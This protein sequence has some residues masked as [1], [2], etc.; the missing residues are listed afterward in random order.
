MMP[1]SRTGR[2]ADHGYMGT[3]PS[4]SR[5]RRTRTLRVWHRALARFLGPF[6][7]EGLA[8]GRSPDGGRLRAARARALVAPACRDRLARDWESLLRAAGERPVP[9]DVRAPLCR[10]RILAAETDIRQLASALRA[11][12]PVPVRGVAMAA[13][14][15]TD[16]SG[17]VY[18]G[19]CATDLGAAV[20]EAIRRTDPWTALMDPASDVPSDFGQ[21]SAS[22]R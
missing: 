5:L 17:P 22:L 6:Q 18:N 2:T 7:D 1:L 14:L 4:T 20:Q 10:R 11:P 8:A 3:T 15:L 12:L 9:L 13:M 19:A 21:D 16:G